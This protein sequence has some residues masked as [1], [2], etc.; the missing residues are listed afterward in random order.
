MAGQRAL[1]CLAAALMPLCTMAAPRVVDSALPDY[2]PRQVQVDPS[3]GYVTAD[4]AVRIAGSE[5]VAYVVARL[6]ALF[7]ESHPAIRLHAEGPGNTAAVPLLTFNRTLVAPM[8]RTIKDTEMAGYRAIVGQDALAVR[9]A[10]NAD[11]VSQSLATALAVYVHRDNP[12][13]SVSAAQVA[14]ALAIGHPAG[15]YSRWGQLGLSG[16]WARRAIRPYGTPES[17]G[18]GTYLQAAHLQGRPLASAY[19]AYGTSAAI[20]ARLAADPAGIAVAAIGLQSAQV[21]QLAIVAQDGTVLTTGT[22]KEITEGRYPY[23]RPLHFYVRKVPGQPIDPLAREYLRL[24]LSRQGQ[25]VMASQKDGYIPLSASDVLHE[26]AKLDLSEAQVPD[27]RMSVAPIPDTARPLDPDLPAYAPQPATPAPGAGYLTN[28]GAIRIAGADHV[29]HIVDGF[30]AL[31]TQSH[32]GT[33]FDVDGK[34]TSS[35]VPLLMFDRT[36]FGA[37]GR[38]INPQESVPFRKIVGR[39][40]LE[41]RVAHT[42]DDTSQHLATSLAVYV[43]RSN[44]IAHVSVRQLARALSIGNPDGDVSRWGQLGLKDSWKNRSI[45]PYGTPEYSG[46]GTY[47]QQH[48]LH[49]LALAPHHERHGSTEQ[50]LQR[51]AADPAGL[52]VAAIGKENDDVRALPIVGEDGT[53]MTTGTPAQVASRTYPLGRALYFYVRKEPGQP[54]DPVTREYLRLVLSYEGQQIIARQHRGY[55]PLTASQARAELAKLD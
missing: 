52:A 30:N 42:A 49:G 11:N 18:F 5:N 12:I 48:I 47:L 36:L 14:R 27:T 33:R 38:A 22:P 35:A 25:T 3:A 16:V 20:L 4:G 43:H 13:Q 21:R 44:P 7:M 55:I 29:R 24:V 2:V 1:F 41:I 51:L 17:S 45:H 10:H 54:V 50:L 26:R 19:E 9:V 40:A 53:T 28:D 31:Y 6:N 8:A 32:P 37:M 39:D 46:F 15:D 34:G 23:A